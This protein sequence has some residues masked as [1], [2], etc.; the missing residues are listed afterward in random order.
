MDTSDSVGWFTV[1]MRDVAGQRPRD[2]RWVKLQGASPA[3]VLISSSLSMV[4]AQDQEAGTNRKYSGESKKTDVGA[5]VASAGETKEQSVSGR[6]SV[7]DGDYDGTE[8]VVVAAEKLQD[9]VLTAPSAA[10]ATTG[11]ERAESIGNNVSGNPS[12]GQRSAGA[13]QTLGEPFETA[14]QGEGAGAT[15]L[16]KT[17]PPPINMT[18]TKSAA[19]LTLPEAEAVSD[20]EALP[21][22][23][24]SSSPDA[25]T[26]SLSISI[27][28]AARLI[29]VAPPQQVDT[30]GAGF[31]FSYSVFGVVVQTD[32]FER[33]ADPG[34]GDRPVLEPM[35]DSFRLR[36]TLHDLC[37][38][39]G[40]AP[41]L[42]VCCR[43]YS[44][45]WLGGDFCVYVCAFVLR[46]ESMSRRYRLVLIYGG[47]DFERPDMK[48]SSRDAVLHK[49]GVRCCS[50]RSVLH[51][52]ISSNGGLNVLVAAA[53]PR[54][55]RSPCLIF[56][57]DPP[58]AHEQIPDI[59]VHREAH[60]RSCRRGHVAPPARRSMERPKR[61]RVRPHG[62]ARRL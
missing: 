3:E 30:T 37:H 36:A 22:G 49:S 51:T 61:V 58:L 24:D 8:T 10:V 59:P 39:L 48:Q 1:D 54:S 44:V 27:K 15:D 28:S 5:V 42:Q 13:V 20:L 7:S 38:F 32:R 29:L 16:N 17:P 40:E 55:K 23:P 12:V 2:E 50:V 18:T 43:G 14:G 26:F 47:L 52:F 25:R 53:S 46:G 35:L 34:P 45:Q 57:P 31:W 4:R 21:V 19:V 60:H 6:A 56:P 9:P 11:L 33:L 41:P 62:D